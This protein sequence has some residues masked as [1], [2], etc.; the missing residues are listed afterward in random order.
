MYAEG[1]NR[2]DYNEMQALQGTKQRALETTQLKMMIVPVNFILER[3]ASSYLEKRKNQIPTSIYNPFIG[4]HKYNPMLSKKISVLMMMLLIATAVSLVGI[5]NIIYKSANIQAQAQQQPQLPQQQLPNAGQVLKKQQPLQLQKPQPL[6][7]GGKPLMTQQRA[8]T[9]NQAIADKQLL[10]RIFPQIIKRIDGKTLATKVLP[11]LDISANVISRDGPT[12]TMKKGKTLLPGQV[13]ADALSST[14]KCNNGEIAV[15]GGYDFQS[16]PADSYVSS[17]APTQPEP[18]GWNTVSLM[19]DDGRI[20]A[21]VL[22]LTI[23]VALKNVP[24][25]QQQPPLPGPLRP[26]SELGG[27]IVR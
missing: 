3:A 8:E 5:S 24:Q 21:S 18:N 2:P 25:S 10:D 20:K 9:L 11:Y 12:N 17:N 4:H 26:P 7:T 22:C 15:G 23:N 19:K 13:G 14:A 27:P 6:G 1:Y 16:D